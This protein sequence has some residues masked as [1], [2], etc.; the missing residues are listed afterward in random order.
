MT[1]WTMRRHLGGY[2]I[3]SPAIVTTYPSDAPVTIYCAK[4]LPDGS[5]VSVWS[6]IRPHTLGH[7]RLRI[8]DGMR[9]V[10][11]LD[12]AQLRA[13]GMRNYQYLAPMWARVLELNR[14][15]R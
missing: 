12:D 14:G 9:A 5:Y 10:E 4:K 7:T 6:S 2:Y 15:K 8:R 1:S 13:L 11:Q 3:F